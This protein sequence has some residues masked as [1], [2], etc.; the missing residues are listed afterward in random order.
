MSVVEHNISISETNRHHLWIT[1]WL[2]VRHKTKHKQ[3]I[4]WLC[5]KHHRQP[6]IRQEKNIVKFMVDR[7]KLSQL[8]RQLFYFFFLTPFVR[9]KNMVH[10]WLYSYFGFVVTTFWISTKT[11]RV[12]CVTRNTTIFFSSLITLTNDWTPLRLHQ[13]SQ[14]VRP[15]LT[16]KSLNLNEG[17]AQCNYPI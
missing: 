10:P 9:L 15:L 1:E 11:N 17:I 6:Y 13:T 4:I 3:T 16:L 14:N 12:S 5:R 8:A 2:L 7:K